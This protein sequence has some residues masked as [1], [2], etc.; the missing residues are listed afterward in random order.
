MT[1]RL[2]PYDRLAEEVKEAKRKTIRKYPEYAREAGFK[3]V[4]VERRVAMVAG[5]N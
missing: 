5:S 3:I 1:N 2:L 4:P